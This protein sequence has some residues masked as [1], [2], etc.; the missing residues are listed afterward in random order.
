MIENVPYLREKPIKPQRQVAVIKIKY[1]TVQIKALTKLG[2]FCAEEGGKGTFLDT[3]A[4]STPFPKFD[5]LYT[6][7]LLIKTEMILV[8]IT[9][10]A[11]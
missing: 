2:N 6:V 5:K 11:L 1:V 9:E 10:D 8:N 7:N 4:M 3:G